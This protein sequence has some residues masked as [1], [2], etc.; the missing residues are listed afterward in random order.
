MLKLNFL[1]VSNIENCFGMLIDWYLLIE[2]ISA[3]FIPSS[4]ANVP[5]VLVNNDKSVVKVPMFVVLVPTVAVNATIKFLLSVV[6]TFKLS[7]SIARLSI[8]VSYSN[9]LSVIAFFRFCIEE[10]DNI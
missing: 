9:I 4:L 8:L 6:N 5:K 3:V 10:Y 7:I 1:C 2:T